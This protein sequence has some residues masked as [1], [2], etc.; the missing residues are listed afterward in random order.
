M[1]SFRYDARGCARKYSKYRRRIVTNGK[2]LRYG[3]GVKIE[4]QA[5][6]RCLGGVPAFAL[7][8]ESHVRRRIP[9]SG[10]RRDKTLSNTHVTPNRLSVG[11]LAAN[12]PEFRSILLRRVL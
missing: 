3:S 1:L 8:I 2:A 7:G 9:T 10:P 12:S 4:L 5:K 6:L 11:G